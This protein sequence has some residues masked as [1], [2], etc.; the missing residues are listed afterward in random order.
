METPETQSSAAGEENTSSLS[1][2]DPEFLYLLM[3]QRQIE[4]VPQQR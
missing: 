4:F 1:S 2:V 3:E